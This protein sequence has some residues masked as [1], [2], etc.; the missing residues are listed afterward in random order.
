MQ[1]ELTEKTRLE[2]PPDQI[3]DWLSDLENWPKI[4]DKIRSISVEGDKC[5]GELLFKG[6][7]IEFAGMVP[8]DNDP[9]KVTCNIVVQTS[10]EK[11]RTEHLTVV[12]EIIPQGRYSKV[13][14]RVIFERS[15]PFWGWLLVKFIMLVGKP[16]GTTNLE[17]IKEHIAAENEE[18]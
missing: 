16:T 1:L 5:I 2:A 17:R 6:Q 14:E 12:Y 3:H 11:N 18:R 8:P 7:T 13:I 10:S 15:I 4:N 9:L